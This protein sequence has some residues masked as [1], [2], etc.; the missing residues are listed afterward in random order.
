MAKRRLASRALVK[1]AAA[2]KELTTVQ[3]AA[4]SNY[5][6]DH[7]GLLI[8]REKLSGKRKGRDWFLRA[9]ELLAYVNSAPKRGRREKS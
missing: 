9:Q 1:A 4:L 2:N 5:T 6:P 8:R 3:A 7:I